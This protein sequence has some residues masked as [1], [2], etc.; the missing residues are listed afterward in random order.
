[1]DVIEEIAKMETEEE[2]E[3]YRESDHR[4]I[5]KNMLYVKD[6]GELAS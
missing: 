6:C 2:L 3:E 1:M 4:P 5:D